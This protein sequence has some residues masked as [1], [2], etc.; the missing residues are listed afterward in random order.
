MSD[1]TIQSAE[2]WW[3]GRRVAAWAAA[4]G[5]GA[6]GGWRGGIAGLQWSR[7]VDSGAWINPSTHREYTLVVAWNGLCL[8]MALGAVLRLVRWGRTDGPLAGGAALVRA[9]AVFFVGEC[10]VTLLRWGVFG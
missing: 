6:L 5:L 2:A 3:R 9:M 1:G 10:A 8:L 7:L 4:L